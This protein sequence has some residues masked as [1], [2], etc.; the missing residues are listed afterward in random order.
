MENIVKVG[1]IVGKA[2]EARNLVTQLLHIL[3]EQVHSPC[4]PRPRIYTELWFGQ[5]PRRV[6]SMSFIHDILSYAG[7]EPIFGN[8]PWSYEPLDLE[9]TAK[10]R[11]NIFLGFYEPEFPVDFVSLAN[12]RGWQFVPESK[13]LVSCTTKGKNIIHDGP[14]IGTTIRWLREHIQ[15]S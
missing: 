8:E 4:E 6:G 5:H 10:L 2:Q 9:E 1:G 14:S 11:P 7:A 15:G 3:Q 13:I 12:K